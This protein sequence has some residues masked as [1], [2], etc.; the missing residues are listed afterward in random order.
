M[1]YSYTQ[2]SAQTVTYANVRYVND[3]IMADLEYVLA[4]YPGV[5]TRD[6]LDNWKL[7]F[8]QW[9]YQGYASAIRAQFYRDGQCFYEIKWD[10]KADGSLIADDNT[11]KIRGQLA[12]AT[13][14]IQVNGTDKWNSLTNDEKQAFYKT[15]QLDWGPVEKTT[16]AAGLTLKSDKQY[17][18]GAFGVHRSILG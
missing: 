2:T 8:Y 16:Y 1:S 17:S 14:S 4:L 10:V 6:R 9:M 5:F 11:G 15:L 3:K 12:G 13:T 18:S 7:D